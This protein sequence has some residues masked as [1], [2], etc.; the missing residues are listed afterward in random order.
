MEKRGSLSVLC[1]ASPATESRNRKLASNH[2]Q[3]LLPGFSTPTNCIIKTEISSCI[4]PMSWAQNDTIRSL[5]FLFFARMS[6]IFTELHS[7]RPSGS[8]LRLCLMSPYRCPPLRFSLWPSFLS[9]DLCL[10]H[11]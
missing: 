1:N 4:P 2:V 6:P 11:L 10:C 5:G 3:T 7:Q 9:V 8:V